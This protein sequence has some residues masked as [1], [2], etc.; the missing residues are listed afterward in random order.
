[1]AIIMAAV[2]DICIVSQKDVRY[3]CLLHNNFLIFA[4]MNN[5]HYFACHYPTRACVSR[6]YVI[7]AG[8]HLYILYYVYDQKKFEWHF[9]G[10]LTFSNTHGRLLVEFIETSSTTARSRNTFLVEKFKDFLI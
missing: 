3:S 4:T 6:G 2:K 5:R 7:G 1:M 10:R 9:S 8:V